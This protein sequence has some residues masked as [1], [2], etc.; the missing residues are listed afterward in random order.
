MELNHRKSIL[1]TCLTCVLSL[2]IPVT[3]IVLAFKA[4]GITPGSELTLLTYD[5]R[6][7]LLPLYG[8][9][10]SGG[11]GYDNLFYSM[12]GGLGG[13]F[14]GTLALYLS[15][16]DL[17]YAIV[18]IKDLPDAIYYIVITK[19]GL[20]GFCLSLYLTG[21]RKFRVSNIYVIILSS[22]YALMSYNIAYYVS[23]MWF[24]AVM[25]LPILA[26]FLERIIEG[27]K[28]K[29]FIL[30]MFLCIVSDYYMAYMV[31]LSLILYFLF[32]MSEE[33]VDF[34]KFLNT[35]ISFAIHGL[36]SVGMSL[37]VIIPVIRDFS[38][39]K[40]SE[41]E[42]AIKGTFLK[43]SVLDVLLSFT[44]QRYSGFDYDV[45]PN[46]F[47]GSLVVV[48]SLIWFVFG[49]KNIK[50]RLTGI[51]VVLLY[52]LSFMFGP[53]D[54]IWHGFRDPVC[55]S[56]RYAFTFDF[57]LVSFAVRGIYT[58]ENNQFKISLCIKK[59]VLY[60][61]F[62]YTLIELYVNGAY[63]ISKVGEDTIFSFRDEY[64]VN[65]AVS[66]HLVPYSLLYETDG[67]GRLLRDSKFSN[68]D[69]ALHGYDGF[70]RFSS[71]YNFAVSSFFRSLGV[72][73]VNH[74]MTEDGFTPPV[75]SLINARYYI[76]SFVDLSY[77][78]DPVASYD[79]YILYENEY[80]LPLAFTVPDTITN[81]DTFSDDPFENINLVYH[82]L[83]NISP[84]REI[85]LPEQYVIS[86]TN[87]IDQ[88]EGN[89]YKNL[90]IQTQ[91]NGHY[92]LM[93]EYDHGDTDV[94]SERDDADLDLYG[95]CVDIGLLE[96]DQEYTLTLETEKRE[97]KKVWLYYFDEEAFKNAISSAKGLNLS[98]IGPDGI[99]I[100]G[101]VSKSE[102]VFLSIP[103]EDGY[104]V[105]VDGLKTNIESYR[106]AF[107]VVP[108]S[109]GFHEIVIKYFPPGL[110][111]GLVLSVVSFF[112]MLS[113][114]IRRK[115]VPVKLQIRE[116]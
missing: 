73:C 40:F 32:R 71:S 87:V 85:F 75:L 81:S 65:C 60:A 98:E 24:D 57:L 114:F 69:N 26:L 35:L 67:Y 88:V 34:K 93:S 29:G 55:F 6:C 13:G 109:E 68:N 15:P 49:K 52:F 25:C 39:G 103:Y 94:D 100:N 47:C 17:I 43:N 48:L 63:I 1:Y 110:K 104:N 72:N 16:F 106:D 90:M 51:I 53:L 19:I 59:V 33:W 91:N 76:G 54:R 115:S 92:F 80:A 112:I 105:Y 64:L 116:G 22:C 101:N 77:I 70:E 18:P 84:D 11:P 20:C 50:S 46:I 58:L 89:L 108:V 44:S 42:Y 96:K 7:Q 27:K 111:V 37:F 36:L 62:A 31:V 83:L 99:S 45:S 61:V 23:P 5:L 3:I 82:E 102:S 14:F 21:I 12:S 30:M 4:N 97:T 10:S 79:G 56:C 8:Y 113:Y 9:L 38:R 95:Y 86:D 2:M 41:G 78:F 107:I 28:S 74:T 66:E